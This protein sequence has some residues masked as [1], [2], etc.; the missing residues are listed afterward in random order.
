MDVSSKDFY[1]I[2]YAIRMAEARK[3]LA[4]REKNILQDMAYYQITNDNK[5]AE[6]YNSQD[7]GFE[8]VIQP[9]GSQKIGDIT[10]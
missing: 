10:N 7:V 6:I 2:M 4:E 8:L 5:T 1:F 9:F 3:T